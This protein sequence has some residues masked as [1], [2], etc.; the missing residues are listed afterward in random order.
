MPAV[1]ERDLPPYLAAKVDRL[2]AALAR[3]AAAQDHAAERDAR[4][5]TDRRGRP[6]KPQPDADSEAANG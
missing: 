2:V 1:I 5:Q 3:L 4:A 6:A